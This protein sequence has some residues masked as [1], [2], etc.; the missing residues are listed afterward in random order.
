MRLDAR[1]NVRGGIYT[2]VVAEHRKK[3]WRGES[4]CSKA[5]ALPVREAARAARPAAPKPGRAD[6]SVDRRAEASD[7]ARWS[8]TR[9]P[10]RLDGLAAYPP[11]AGT[12]ELREAIAGVAG[13]AATASRRSTRRPRCCRSTARARRCSPS[14]RPCSIRR[15]RRASCA[16]IRSTRSTKARRC[17]P[18]PRPVIR[19]RPTS[20]ERRA[21]PLRLLARQPDRQGAWRWRTGSGCSSCP[22]ATASSS[23]PTSA[24]PRSTSTRPPLGALQAARQLDATDFRSLV[25]FSSLSKRS[26]APGMRSGFVAGDAALLKKFLLYRTYHGSAM[27]L[28]VQQASIAAWNDEAARAARTAACTRRNSTRCCR[29]SGSRRAAPTAASTCGCSTPIDDAEFVRR[30]HA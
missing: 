29:C 19:R 20:L 26:N 28:A 2:T 10:A 22:T 23:P 18:A 1:F 8:R 3:G 16:P 9:S 13:A 25:V 27:S 14:R 5:P 11:T 24:T 7:A 21:A 15:A 4:R 6:Q 12:P 17:S 30:L